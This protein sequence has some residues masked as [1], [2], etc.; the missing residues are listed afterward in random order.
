MAHR[1]PLT[2][3]ATLLAL[4]AVLSTGCKAK[5]APAP[6]GKRGL[7]QPSFP[8]EV[9][10]VDAKPRELAVTAPGVVDAFEHV[11]VTARVSG[12]VDKVSFVEGQEV[13]RGQI[14][15]LIDSRRYALS[16]SSARAAVAKAQAT[17]ADV[18]QSL[19][20]RE[21]ASE[22]NPGLVAGEEIET[23]RTRLRTAQADADQAGEALKLAQLNL[24]DS[25]VKAAAE[26]TIQTR[27]VQTGQF[28]Q[29]GA[30]LATLLQREPMLLHFSVTT[31]EAPRLKIGMPV[32]FTLKESQQ[33]YA[34]K[35][36]LVGG[37]ADPESR[38]VPVT[39]EIDA[40][41]KFWL[42]P[43]SFAAVSVKL[44]SQRQ[45][46]M[47]PQSAARP[48]DRGFVAFVIQ[49]D[50]AHE[51]LLELG[52]HTSDGWVEVHRGIDAGDQIV[53]RG[54]E[55]LAEGTK[56]QV[57]PATPG[58]SAAAPGPAA[59]GSPD[60]TPASSSGRSG[61]DPETRKRRAT[62]GAASVGPPAA[63]ASANPGAG[64]AP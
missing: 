38:L 47:I 33:A 4:F 11:Q 7:K 16:V 8:V 30:V 52:M 32:D 49:G 15:A 57:S 41:R 29:A 6:T 46:P 50:T 54:V 48:S 43:G 25:Q 44:T 22:N 58:G 28:L 53:T 35:I 27:S 5:E 39:A 56:V 61:G 26:G 19:K 20:R 51:K 24:D 14:L 63:A 36:T 59:S 34:A 40:G 23:F 42:R 17:A 2:F 45:F 10:R 1:S 55:A 9:L 21:T 31:A 18:Q 64:E 3:A 62:G 12:V 37:S 60:T 13:K